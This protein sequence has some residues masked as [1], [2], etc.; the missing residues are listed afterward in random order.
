MRTSSLGRRRLSQLDLAVQLEAVE[1]TY[2]RG[3]VPIRALAGV[4]LVVKVGEVLAVMGPS[5]SGKTTLLNLV[6]A[7]DRATSGVVEVA[8]ANLGALSRKELTMF[9][10]QHVG[11]VFQTFN[12]VPVL[13]A[14]EN[15]ELPMLF[16]N[17]KE[18]V[19]GE[20]SKALLER[21]G[22]W[23]RAEHVPDQLSGGEQQRVAIARALAN[24]P[25]L[26]LADEP[27]GELDED[28][29]GQVMD[30]LLR[31]VHAVSKTMIVVTHDPQVAQRADRVLQLRNGAIVT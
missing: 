16:A 8:G 9:R 27:T 6:G 29:G 28:T 15:I 7:L 5:G 22:L 23:D 18:A 12:L 1:K 26:I 21:V 13:S 31:I 30:E 11:F 25:E 3:D 17:T 4:D 2:L 10:R 19:R 14:R 20:R 24:D